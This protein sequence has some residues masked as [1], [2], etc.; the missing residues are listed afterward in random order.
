MVF[1]SKY[2]SKFQAL[3]EE[4]D[5]LC[6]YPFSGLTINPDGRIV[7]CCHQ[8]STIQ[9]LGHISEVDDLNDFFNYGP[10]E[11][12]R[13]FMKDKILPYKPC[14]DC[15]KKYVNS[16]QTPFQ[17]NNPRLPWDNNNYE[18][19][20]K[21]IRYL[22]FTPSNLCNQNCVMCGSPYSSKWDSIDQI[23]IRNGEIKFRYD[24]ANFRTDPSGTYKLSD[25]DYQKIIKCITEGVTKLYIKGGEPFADERNIDLL[26]R[27]AY[28]EFPHIQNIGISTNFK[29]LDKRIIRII[30]DLTYKLNNNARMK[31]YPPGGFNMS[32]SIDGVGKQYDWIRGS[33]WERLVENLNRI[34]KEVPSIK[35]SSSVTMTAYNFYNI[36][37]I[38]EEISKL[39]NWANIN[40]RLASNPLYVNPWYLVPEKDIK[41][42]TTLYKD[43]IYENSFYSKLSKNEWVWRNEAKS[44]DKDKLVKNIEEFK[45]FTSFMNRYRGFDIEDYIPEIKTIQI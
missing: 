12:I 4:N 17:I 15:N 10:S 20:R 42:Y 3:F 34:V 16:Q 9:T 41:K 44:I 35:W 18:G 23:A 28:E 14:F 45:E 29:R 43:K 19:E 6:V 8:A 2:D 38:F 13:N 33:S 39:P 26:E 21:T 25:E 32:I 30:H 31:R 27:I 7:Q 24:E 1:Y 11:E 36:D 5:R 37:K 40:G 22:E